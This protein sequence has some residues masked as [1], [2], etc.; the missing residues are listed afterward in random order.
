MPSIKVT[1]FQKNI[2]IPFSKEQKAKIAAQNSDF[3][4][5]PRFF[6]FFDGWSSQQETKEKKFLD[7]I[8]EISEYHK[9]VVIGGSIFRK[10]GKNYIESYPIVKDVNL[11]DYYNLRSEDSLGNI[12]VMPCNSEFIFTL[13]G[14]RFAVLPGRDLHN[15]ELFEQV[16]SEKIELIFNPDFT[17]LSPQ[18]AQVYNSEL[19]TYTNI[20]KDTSLQIVRVCG[21][22]NFG[23]FV[24]SGRS[25]YATPSGIRWKVASTENQIEVIKTVNVALREGI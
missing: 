7:Q 19:S 4:I 5:L 6:P 20:V 13:N 3:L 2:N 18:E 22:G 16:K 17:E 1:I 8:L 14:I 9:G 25:F 21:I 15:P 10:D 11:I 12:K 24:L 23:E